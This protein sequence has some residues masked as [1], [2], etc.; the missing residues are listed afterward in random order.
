[1]K[2]LSGVITLLMA[3]IISGVAAYFSVVGLAALF[4]A[5]MWPVIIMGASL[6]A[7][8]LVA[9]QWLHENWANRNV[10]WFHKSYLVIAVGV[11]MGITAI[12]IYGFLSKGH[13]EQKAPIAGIELQIAQKEQSIKFLEADNQ[14]LT[15]KLN[16]LDTSVNSFLK[17]D[18]ATAGLAA[19]NRQKAE[20]K[21]I[22]T[23]MA[24]NNTKIKAVYDELLPLKVSTSEVE[25]KLGPVKYVADLFG[26]QDP[27]S[28]VRLIILLIMVAFD[29]LAVALLISA[30]ISLGEWQAS[31]KKEEVATTP[32][33]D[34]QALPEPQ[35]VVDMQEPV[36]EPVVEPIIDP[37]LDSLLPEVPKEPQPTIEPE[38]EQPVTVAVETAAKPVVE[39]ILQPEVKK[40]I[41][42]PRK[43]KA[44]NHDA[45]NLA[46]VAD[47]YRDPQTPSEEERFIRILEDRPDLIE[48]VAD[49]VR[50]SDKS[51]EESDTP[52]PTSN[53][54]QPTENNAVND[55]I[56]VPKTPTGK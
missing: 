40:K 19:R 49:A 9:A 10:T 26:W 25:A 45:L 15:D 1:M 44:F 3:V 47:L 20:R 38:V 8:K 35:P 12:G 29:P 51:R 6:E 17:G 33:S 54:P 7:G 21:D 28:A 46:Q 14:R 41:R 43:A 2:F 30:S 50:D 4:A 53:G 32:S 24:E 48:K 16:Q 55:W 23:Q 52:N 5:T 37:V 31:K 18:K 22:D 11:L 13:L 34:D 36:A 42:R 39:V 27:N 56:P